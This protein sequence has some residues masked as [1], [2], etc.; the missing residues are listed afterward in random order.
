MNSDPSGYL[1]EVLVVGGISA[2]LEAQYNA[3]VV[4]TGLAI[5][6]SLTV[7]VNN[8]NLNILFNQLISDLALG[9]DVCYQDI[10]AIILKKYSPF[11][12]LI[13][14]IQ[15]TNVHYAKNKSKKKN[16]SKEN[17]SLKNENHT[18]KNN[19]AQNKQVDSISSKLNL[20]KKQRR[21]F[22]DEISGQ[23]YSYQELLELAIELFTTSNDY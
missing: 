1:A 10:L 19:K 4:T 3:V 22:H 21:Q 6:A 20:N 8:Y 14:S 11:N 2:N 15:A 12:Q 7:T 5:I 13:N 18:P 16:K 9:I 17:K 23:G